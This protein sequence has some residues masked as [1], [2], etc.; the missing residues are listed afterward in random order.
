MK[1]VSWTSPIPARPGGMS[2]HGKKVRIVPESSI[3]YWTQRFVEKGVA[4]EKPVKLSGT[5]KTVS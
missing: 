5:L 1:T 4:H 3:G 2:P